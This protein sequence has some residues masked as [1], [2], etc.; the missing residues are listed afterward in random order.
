V[1]DLVE[2]SALIDAIGE[3]E[4]A[5]VCGCDGRRCFPQEIGGRT[6]YAAHMV[7][8]KG[9]KLGGRQVSL[10]TEK[11]YQ[12]LM[13]VYA[14]LMR[15]KLRAAGHSAGCVAFN[16]RP[17]GDRFKCVCPNRSQQCQ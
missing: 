5:R 15:D 8:A 3:A 6:Y 7:R 13:R 1:P 14:N 9:A 2:K 4:F 16:A 17:L 12:D 10:A 11:M